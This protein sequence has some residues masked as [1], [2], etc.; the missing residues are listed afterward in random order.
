MR[1]LVAAM[2]KDVKQAIRTLPWRELRS[3]EDRQALELG[4]IYDAPNFAERAAALMQ[5]LTDKW[6]LLFDAE[7]E[8]IGKRMT[9]GTVAASNL[10]LGRSMR[11][12]GEA[13]TLSI[14]PRLQLQID[15]STQE[16]AALIKRVPA[17]Y[18]PQIQG[19]V[20]RSIT[21]GNGLAD[22]I[23]QLEKRNVQVK[24]WAQNVA[25]DQ[26]RK[27]Y[28]GINKV[29]MEEAGLDEYEWV[30]SGGANQPRE[31]H[32]HRWP[33]GLNGGIFRW[34]DPPVADERTGERAHPGVLPYCG[35]IARPVLRVKE[36]KE[37]E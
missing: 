27:A 22:L 34:D 4:V 19:D 31:H 14:G 20:M 12:L 15:A 21:T 2:F 8:A 26:T 32:M 30:H 1:R 11:E 7:S 35:C 24:N 23:P 13:M 36:V 5:S 37:N 10:Q 25:R 6:G 33:A 3:V 9:A 29:R 16:A 18:I 28:A 17:Q